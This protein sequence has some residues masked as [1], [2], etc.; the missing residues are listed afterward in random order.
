[1]S[2]VGGVPILGE[3]FDALPETDAQA[4]EDALARGDYWHA[5]FYCPAGTLLSQF[6]AGAGDDVDDDQELDD[7]DEEEQ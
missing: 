3:I 6:F 2:L 1:M 7:E 5:S 4:C